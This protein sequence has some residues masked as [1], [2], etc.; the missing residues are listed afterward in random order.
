MPLASP[1]A[2]FPQPDSWT[3]YRLWFAHQDAVLGHDTAAGQLRQPP[4]LGCR[5]HEVRAVTRSSSDGRYDGGRS[6]KSQGH[7][8]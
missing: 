4:R 7:P 5:R 3:E 2:R 1:A 8:N 6:L